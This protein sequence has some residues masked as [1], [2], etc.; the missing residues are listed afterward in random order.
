MSFIPANQ[1][2]FAFVWGRY[3]RRKTARAR[4]AKGHRTAGRSGAAQRGRDGRLDNWWSDL[5]G[6]R[7]LARVLGLSRTT[8]DLAGRKTL[9]NYFR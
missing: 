5:D 3:S 1:A 6:N 9:Q 7:R 8:R 4:W 2:A